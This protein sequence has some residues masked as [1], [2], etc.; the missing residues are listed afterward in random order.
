MRLAYRISTT[1]ENPGIAARRQRAVDILTLMGT[2]KGLRQTL[3]N[4]LYFRLIEEIERADQL[5][6][7]DYLLLN[8]DFLD[9]TSRILHVRNS[10]Y[11]RTRFNPSRRV[12]EFTEAHNI[13]PVDRWDLSHNVPIRIA[14]FKPVPLSAFNGIIV[15]PEPPY[16]S[17]HTKTLERLAAETGIS[18]QH[19]KKK[20][21]HLAVYK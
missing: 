12:R 6:G 5:D 10:E 18:F 4:P 19:V 14:S 16:D 17:K 7:G 11:F 20:G 1:S 13:I 9:A 21:P 8:P 15:K 2:D 3:D